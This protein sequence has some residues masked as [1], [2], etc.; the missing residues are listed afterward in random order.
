VA[1]CSAAN[2]SAYG[3]FAVA[4]HAFGGLDCHGRPDEPSSL[5]AIITTSS[6]LV[7]RHTPAGS[8]LSSSATT[9]KCAGAGW[10]CRNG[11]IWTPDFAPSNGV[12]RGY[13]TAGSL[14]ASFPVAYNYPIGAAYFGDYFWV[15][16]S[17]SHPAE[18]RI[19]KF[20]CPGVMP[21]AEQ[22]SLGRVEA[23]YR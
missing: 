4:E 14:T 6:Y 1:R 9:T 19:Y 16:F 10:D 12:A 13:T 18:S 2:R 7:V 8:F 21:A 20:H 11:L 15:G 22:A 3:S 17:P 23:L 5:V